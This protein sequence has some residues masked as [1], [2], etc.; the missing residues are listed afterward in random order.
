MARSSRITRELPELLKALDDHQFLL[1]QNLHGLAHDPA[2][3]KI[4]ASELRTLT[5]LSSGTD[6]LLWRVADALAIS[7]RFTDF[8]E[9]GLR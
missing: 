3:I 6:G 4:L 2:H 1:R 8:C 7:F 9:T 5:C